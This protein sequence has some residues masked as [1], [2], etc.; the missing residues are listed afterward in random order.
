MTKDRLLAVLLLTM[1]TLHTLHCCAVWYSDIFTTTILNLLT[2]AKPTQT[3]IFSSIFSIS[4]NQINN[5]IQRLVDVLTR[6]LIIRYAFS[7]GY[8]FKFVF[9]Y[10]P[11]DIL[12]GLIIYNMLCISSYQRTH[13]FD[14]D[15]C[16]CQTWASIPELSSTPALISFSASSWPLWYLGYEVLPKIVY[17][18][19]NNSCNK[20][21]FLSE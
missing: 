15:S 17:T 20:T 3:R 6:Y 13:S 2:S 7:S 12:I 4:L 9:T 19:H 10:L 14:N 18:K 8:K 16:T 21:L 5:L 11:L 1:T